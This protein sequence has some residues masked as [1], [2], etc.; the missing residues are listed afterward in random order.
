MFDIHWSAS[1]LVQIIDHDPWRH[2]LNRGTNHRT[3]RHSLYI[4]S[5]ACSASLNKQDRYLTA[6]RGARSCSHN[7]THPTSLSPDE[8]VTCICFSRVFRLV[9]VLLVSEMTAIDT[10]AF[11]SP[12]FQSR[13]VVQKWN[14]WCFLNFWASNAAMRASSEQTVQICC[15]Y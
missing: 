6:F 8:L 9:L 7:V 12:K 5:C 11:W 14:S 1:Q 15:Q 3:V 13:L 4:V 2:D 10:V